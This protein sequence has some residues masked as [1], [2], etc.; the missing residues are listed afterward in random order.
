VVKDIRASMSWWI[1]EGKVGPW[2][3]LDSFS[4]AEQRYRGEPTTAD[5]SIAMAVAGHMMIELIQ[6]KGRLRFTDDQR[7]RLAAK[8]KPLAL[9]NPAHVERTPMPNRQQ[10]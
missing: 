9:P 3:L 2:F 10:F 6:P 4:G 7:I 8:A 5:V 1:H